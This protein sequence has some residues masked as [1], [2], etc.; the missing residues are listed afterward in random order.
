[1]LKYLYLFLLVFALHD[2]GFA[3]DA[4]SSIEQNRNIPLRL[5]KIKT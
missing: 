4:Q 5:G 2:G 1:M 3:Q